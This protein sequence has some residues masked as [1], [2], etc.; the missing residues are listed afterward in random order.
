MLAAAGAAAVVL[1]AF[2]LPVFT[3]LRLELG[4]AAWAFWFVWL[5]PFLS[6]PLSYSVRKGKVR[7]WMHRL[8]ECCMG[9]VMYISLAFILK[10]A[11]LLVL[12]AAGA[13]VTEDV[14]IFAGR[15]A[16]LL[17]AALY[18]AG[19]F[20]ALR[21]KT[22]RIS[23]PAP[24]E[25]GLRLVLFSDLHLGFFTGRRMTERIA[26]A[27]NRERP[28]AV[29]IAGDIFDMD[30]ASLRDPERHSRAVR[31]MEAPLGIYACL[32][33]HDM[34]ADEPEKDA[35]IERSGVTVLRDATAD[36]GEVT[37]L[38]R[39]D[40]IDG[41]RLSPEE[42]YGAVRA[43]AYTVVL[44][45]NPSEYRSEWEHGASLLLC[46]HTHGGQTFPLDIVQKLVMPMPV[47]GLHCAGGKRLFVTSGAGFWGPPLRLGVR[48]EI[49]RIDLVP[50]K[51]GSADVSDRP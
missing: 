29:L 18:L 10:A 15:A 49:V 34:L 24:V 43:G 3:W 41:A 28:D 17:F 36:L 2:G 23:I 32:G 16:F 21:I 50:E 46:G 31:S 47:Y 33:N 42:A 30:Y 4:G 7:T 12:R 39:R 26:T 51:S 40:V 38:G 25:R 8:G 37:L 6:L 35:W 13:E 22:V 44:D 11:V 27:V 19:V 1:A 48:N 5:V 45:H 9:A 14:R 20:T